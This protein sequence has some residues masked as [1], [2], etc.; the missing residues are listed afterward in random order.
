[1]V[2]MDVDATAFAFGACKC[3]NPVALVLL[4]RL[5]L[6][7]QRYFIKRRDCIERLPHQPA[8][9]A[10]SPWKKKEHTIELPSFELAIDRDA[11]SPS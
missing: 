2:G 4:R 1:M 9:C 5:F 6:F 10:F 3:S 8:L 11:S 7:F